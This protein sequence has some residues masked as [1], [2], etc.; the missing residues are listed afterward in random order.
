MN[1]PSRP[2]PDALDNGWNQ[3]PNALQ[4]ATNND[5]N[6]IANLRQQRGHRIEHEMPALDTKT[7][8]AAV[9]QDAAPKRRMKMGFR[10]RNVD[11]TTIEHTQSRNGG[12]PNIGAPAVGVASPSTGNRLEKSWMALRRFAKFI[13]PGFMVA[14]AYIDPGNY[15]T[16]IA[17]GATYK[18]QLLVMVLASNIIAIF[19]QSLCI[20]LGSVTGM[21]LAENIREHCPRWLNYVLYFL[22][23]SA[24]I[25][26]D[27]AEV[28]PLCAL[29]LRVF[30]FPFS[31]SY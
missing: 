1:C 17:A 24:I 22:A 14:V 4:A 9:T 21:N 28:K 26:T 19:L 12:M 16:D 2:D 18:Y 5:S 3:N 6:G 25:A 13:G 29:I 8:G 20:K 23:E 10:E 11:V 15:S 31:L 30:F 7:L 27:I